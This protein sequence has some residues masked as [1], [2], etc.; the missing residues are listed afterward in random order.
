[1]L[2][3]ILKPAEGSDPL[4]FS[5]KIIECSWDSDR[6]EW[7]Y[8][9]IRTDKSTPND[10]NTYR[11]VLCQHLC[12]FISLDLSVC[13]WFRPLGWSITGD[14]KYKRQYHRGYPI[15]WNK[16]DNSPSHVCRQDKNWQQ[17]QSPSQHGPEKVI[18]QKFWA[19]DISWW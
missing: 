9:R 19:C 5:G 18:D 13:T 8:K 15:E 4:H 16:W 17:S 14:A 6:Q 10:F 7:I 12:L 1:L 2:N 11:K 3:G